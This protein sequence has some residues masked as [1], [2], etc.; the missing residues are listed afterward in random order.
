MSRRA[1]AV[2][3]GEHYAPVV[4]DALREVPYDVVAAVLIGGTEKLR[5]GEDY[6]VPLAA[7]LALRAARA[8]QVRA[9]S[10]LGTVIVLAAVGVVATLSRGAWLALA[11]VV[12]TLALGVG[13]RQFTR[14]RV[15]VAVAGAALAAVGVLVV[16]GHGWEQMAQR[17][18]RIGDGAGR[19]ELWKA[20]VS[21]AADR[22]LTDVVIEHIDVSA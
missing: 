11:S 20:A 16:R 7:G 9:A 17:V 10:V 8:G 22:P 5:G 1:V 19:V 14:R 18:R 6:G 2:I 13:W 4:R 12:G 15:A 3:D 21:M